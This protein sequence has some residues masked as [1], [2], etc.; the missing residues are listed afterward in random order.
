MITLSEAKLQLNFPAD[1]DGS[2]DEEVQAYVDAAGGVVER[3]TGEVG[4]V[5]TITGERRAVGDSWRL[6]LHNKP[7]QSLTSIARVDGSQTWNVADLDVETDAGLIRVVDGPLLS[8]LLEITYEAGHVNVPPNFN[9]AA[10]IIVQHLW[11][12]Q[13]GT[14][15]LGD[16]RSTMEASFNDTT[17]RRGYAIPNAALELLGESTPVVA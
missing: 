13:R 8:G 12:T 2:Q 1:D 17:V 15:G 11:Q 5:R 16:V 10:R 14:M 7:V 9:L 6:W 3:H 4:A